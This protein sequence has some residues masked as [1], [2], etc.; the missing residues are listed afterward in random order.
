M[1]ST[2][3]WKKYLGSAFSP[4]FPK[5]W[6]LV[7]QF[8]PAGILAFFLTQTCIKAPLGNKTTLSAWTWPL[9]AQ[10]SMPG[11]LIQENLGII[12]RMSNRKKQFGISLPNSGGGNYKRKPWP[13]LRASLYLPRLQKDS[14]EGSLKYFM[15]WNQN[16]PWEQ[17][18]QLNSLCKME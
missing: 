8:F 18:M 4:D 11:W 10:I 2:F 17:V 3:L 16:Q 7:P 13:P 9:D 6:G 1:F 15:A 5:H 14:Q 12:L